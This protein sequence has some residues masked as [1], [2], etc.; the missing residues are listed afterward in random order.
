MSL[1]LIP[2]PMYHSDKEEKK[3]EKCG[4]TLPTQGSDSMEGR[5]KFLIIF[6]PLTLV[7]IYV[8]ITLTTWLSPG[9][10]QER[11]SLQEVIENQKE[12]V[13]DFFSSTHIFKKNNLEG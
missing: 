8:G 13:M 5:G 10:Y 7:L 2:M 1:M 9:Y 6:I 11:I 4:Q 12:D 3:C